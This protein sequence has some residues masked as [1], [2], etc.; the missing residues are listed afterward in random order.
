MNRT[1]LCVL[2]ALLLALPASAQTQS[3]ARNDAKAFG[4][5]QQENL[6]GV[7][8]NQSNPGEVPNYQGTNLPESAYQ[9]GIMFDDA[10]ERAHDTSTP[11]GEAATLLSDSFANRP[12]IEVKRSD[13]WMQPGLDA[14]ANPKS[15]VDS[16][17]GRYGE[18]KELPGATLP[19]GSTY[20]T[21][22]V[23][24]DLTTSTCYLERLVSVDQHHRYRCD[25]VR[26]SYTVSCQNQLRVSCD[27]VQS[28]GLEG[29]QVSSGC[30]GVS[31]GM[32]GN[33]I[34]IGSDT[35]FPNIG[36]AMCGGPGNSEAWFNIY[37]PDVNVLESLR[38]EKVRYGAR[39]FLNVYVNDQH[40][41]GLGQ[42]NNTLAGDALNVWAEVK[43][44]LRS[45]WNSVHL[46]TNAGAN[47]GYLYMAGSTRRCGQW[48]ETWNDG[49]AGYY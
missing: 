41:L 5:P 31:A 45:G 33:A 2:A 4:T 6:K 22:D 48:R 25:K 29:A 16:F 12:K 28:T 39:D 9:N 32:S 40:V 27:W 44:V 35:T 14:E 19:G 18:C 38:I 46:T 47:I 24:S 11:E 15:L 21:C 10:V 8:R 37:I 43:H 26:D 7:A 23:W 34:W 13:A 20:K 36:A 30:G 17:T 42:Y 3:D 49:C 1:A